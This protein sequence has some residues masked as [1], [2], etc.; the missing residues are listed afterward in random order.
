MPLGW[1]QVVPSRLKAPG[2]C[3]V[4]NLEKHVATPTPTPRHPVLESGTLQF[5]QLLASNTGRIGR[6]ICPGE[7]GRLLETS[8]ALFN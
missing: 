6:K 2:F 1:F 7:K 5:R 8:G 4:Q 3:P